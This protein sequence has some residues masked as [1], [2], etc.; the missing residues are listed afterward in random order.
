MTSIK[1]LIDN[2]EQHLMANLR[3]K[4]PD[5]YY[6]CANLIL[7][8]IQVIINDKLSY[9]IERKTYT[10]LLASITDGRY[11]DQ[12]MRLSNLSSDIRVIILIEGDIAHHNL[13]NTVISC[14]A[15]FTCLGLSIIPTSDLT[16]TC[17]F[18][19]NLDVKLRSDKPEYHRSGGDISS[20]AGKNRVCIK[21]VADTYKV[22][23]QSIPKLSRGVISSIMAKYPTLFSLK[24]VS[25]EDLV[26]IKQVGKT[27]A[28]KIVAIIKEIYNET[29]YNET[30]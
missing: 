17:Y 7:G 15:T 16:A 19:Q 29:T 10:D 12:A 5:F 22:I 13:N 8:D 2:R 11:R 14:F 30:I 9:V 18:L 6:E 4:S 21:D 27:T 25:V 3:D 24:Q 28:E 23:L 26:K 1:F 20:C